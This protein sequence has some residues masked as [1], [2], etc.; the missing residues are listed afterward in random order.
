M[1][2]FPDTPRMFPGPIWER[3]TPTKYSQIPLKGIWDLGTS[4]HDATLPGRSQMDDQPRHGST[5]EPCRAW[6][7]SSYGA[8]VR[9]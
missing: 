3:N 5:A 1:T 4:L 6:E 7:G 2:T 9:E 8:G